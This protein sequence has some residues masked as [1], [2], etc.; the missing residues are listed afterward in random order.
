MIE[1]KKFFRTRTAHKLAC[2]DPNHKCMS[3]HGEYYQFQI[4]LRKPGRIE[5]CPEHAMVVDFGDIKEVAKDLIFDKF[6]HA[7]LIYKNDPH[8]TNFQEIGGKL[9]VMDHPP[10]VEYISEYAYNHLKEDKKIGEYLYKVTVVESED[11][12]ASYWED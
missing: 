8:L 9:L 7:M 3:T 11:C 4:V 6:D 5:D 12:E 1:V 10:T 2:L